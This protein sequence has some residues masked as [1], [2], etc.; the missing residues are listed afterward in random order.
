MKKPTNFDLIE[1]CDKAVQIICDVYGE[2]KIGPFDVETQHIL[3][4]NTREIYFWV[5]NAIKVIF[6]VNPESAVQRKGK[7]GFYYDLPYDVQFYGTDEDFEKIKN[8]VEI[9]KKMN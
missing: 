6:D 8:A 3:D 5:G 1:I 9:L 2:E 4:E 7:N